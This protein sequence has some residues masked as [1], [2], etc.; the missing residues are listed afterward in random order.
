[1]NSCVIRVNNEDGSLSS[2]SVVWRALPRGV[3]AGDNSVIITCQEFGLE[4]VLSVHLR[5][6]A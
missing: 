6:R 2:S 4:V 5:G 3:L 1:M